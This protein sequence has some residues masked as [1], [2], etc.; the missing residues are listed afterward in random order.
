[1]KTSF[2]SLTAFLFVA[3]AFAQQNG[4]AITGNIESIFQY[5]EDDPVIDATQ[6]VQKGLLNS[7]MNVFY[8]DGTFKAGIRMESY[9]PSIQ[10]YPANFD[11]TGLGMRY[12]GYQ[13]DFVEVTLG[14]IYE[15]FG[16]GLAFRSYEDRALGYDN[17]LDGAR[18][19]LKPGKGLTVKGV[20]GLQR[21]AFRDGR[22][23][24][25]EGIVR[26][27]D[28]EW[29]IN[30][31]KENWKDK[32]FNLTVGAS[33]V[34]KYQ[35]DDVD[36]IVIPQNVGA[37]GARVNMRYGKFTLNGEYIFKGQDPSEDQNQG[38]GRVIYNTGHAAVINF[39]Y[40]RKGLG[41][42]LSAK[43]ADNMSYRS[44]RNQTLQNALI[45]FLPAMNKVHS[46]NLVASLYPWAT[47]PLGEVAFQ[48]EVVYTVKNKSPLFGKYGTTFN[49]NYS[50][51]YKPERTYYAY[52]PTDTTGVAYETSPFKMSDSLYWSDFNFSIYRKL[53]KKLNVRFSYFNIMMNN[54]VNKVADN[55]KDIIHSNIYVL[56]AGYKI[57]KK[58]SLRGELQA[59][60][61]N[62]VK[63]HL[64]TGEEVV[65]LNDKGNW[66]TGL[67]E[68]NVSPH[69]FFSILDQINLENKESV[70]SFNKIDTGERDTDFFGADLPGTHHLYYSVGYIRESTRISIGYGRQRAGLFCVGGICRTVPASYGLTVSFTQSF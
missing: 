57:N 61:I 32:K 31:L 60:F 30:S 55:G 26:G 54:N 1:M 35:P 14:S 25:S 28:A 27:V 59:L 17:F 3:G 20:Y 24:H 63:L 23:E 52:D 58:H 68:Y 8:N 47:Q 13:N 45:N 12:I 39:G 36:S 69:W 4:P 49:V 41:V 18:V 2:L 70:Y 7:Y 51:A 43:S 16:N 10:G 9:L 65:V 34:S 15:Q 64:P 50:T 56:E 46:Y 33:L 40:S 37:Y 29:N 44:D 66:I 67:I 42:L 53:N 6:P 19:I 21:L 5:L 38:F 22:I 11:G 62:S 48:G